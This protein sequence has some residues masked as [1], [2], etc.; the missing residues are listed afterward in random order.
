MVAKE[1]PPNPHF[2]KAVASERLAF[3]SSGNCSLEMT[4]TIN[5]HC[6][7]LRTTLFCWSLQTAQCLVKLQSTVYQEGRWH[8][9]VKNLEGFC[10]SNL[11]NNH[12]MQPNEKQ[13]SECI[14]SYQ[15]CTST[16]VQ[17]LGWTV[18][19]TLPWNNALYKYPAKRI[20]NRYLISTVI[21]EGWL[22]T[23]EQLIWAERFNMR[24]SKT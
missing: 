9:G 1:K 13:R 19:K 23:A 5:E 10:L 4:E 15:Q 21:R 7:I 11:F 6:I 22:N 8:T 20:L 3:S 14:H 18:C 24:Q 17:L 16:H 2:E 12:I